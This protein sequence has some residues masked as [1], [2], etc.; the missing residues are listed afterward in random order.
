MI[1]ESTPFRWPG[2]WKNPSALSLL[3]GTPINYVLVDN[4]PEFESV[5]SGARQEGLQV[6]D[7][8]ALPP[9]I[10][11]V[12]GEWAGVRMSRGSGGGAS[13]GP[14]GVPWVN[15]NGWAVRLAGALHP[16]TAVWVEA[17][18]AENARITPDSYLITMSDSACHGGRWVITLDAPFAAALAARSPV[19]IASWKQLCDAAAF[20][21]GHKE[22]AGY[23]PQAIVGVISDYAGDNEFFGGELLNLL[24]RA[25]QHYRI[26]LKD[27][28]SEASLQGLRAV[29]Y[30]DAAPASAALRSRILSFVQAGGMLISGPKWGGVSTPPLPAE[31][32]PR[33]A[34]HALGKGRIALA[35]EEQSDPYVWANDSVVMV[36]HRYDLVRFWN[37]GA[38][39]SFYTLSP[40][41]K[42]A[43]VHLLFYSNRGPDAAS[44]R[45][46]GRY[47]SAR[48]STVDLPA[49]RSVE[50]VSQKDAV[51]V[52]LP[53]VPQYV[54]LELEV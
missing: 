43:V 53:Q 37:G 3:R 18:P 35:K 38:T 13:A 47:R 8:A 41:R 46:V 6:A 44:I 11:L 54:A 4:G 14:T 21:A 48:I 20:F 19:S 27:K 26:L 9:G 1:V 45:V 50:M 51:E 34:L 30:A 23:E 7:P 5:R 29:I 10:S 31:D 2:T 25:G 52:H 42:R 28:V 15:S 16:S 40:D 32:H 24:S 17:A 39:G 49:A 33:F 36:S 22:W 12:K